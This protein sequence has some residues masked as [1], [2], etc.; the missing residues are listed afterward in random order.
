MLWAVASRLIEIG[1][2]DVVL[3]NQ[4]APCDALTSL[5]THRLAEPPVSLMGTPGRMRA[6]PGLRTGCGSTQ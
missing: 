4:A 3:L 2:S 1:A 6:A 5:V